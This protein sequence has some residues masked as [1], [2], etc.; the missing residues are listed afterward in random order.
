MYRRR[1]SSTCRYCWTSGH[2]RRTCPELKKNATNGDENAKWMIE[3]MKP[4]PGSRKCSY[5]S[6]TDHNKRGCM[7]FVADKGAYEKINKAWVVETKN[8]M[9]NN[10]YTVGSLIYIPSRDHE[11][12]ADKVLA[13]IEKLTVD[14]RLPDRDW[15]TNYN[16]A[17]EANQ[18]EYHRYCDYTNRIYGTRHKRRER[19]Y[20]IG[21]SMT[22]RSVSGTGLGYWKE[23]DS[24]VVDWERVSA[25]RQYFKVIG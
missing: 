13:I 14:D 2:T 1:R 12:W 23:N 21:A 16:N 4:T 15:L 18:D 6:D 5:C 22:F 24:C 17:S 10:G 20:K 25:N 8:A 19:T 7:Q 3:K 11:A 9:K